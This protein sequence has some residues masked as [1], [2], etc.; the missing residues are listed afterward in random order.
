M[1][2]AA[3]GMSSPVDRRVITGSTAPESTGKAKSGEIHGSFPLGGTVQDISVQEGRASEP[4]PPAPPPTPSDSPTPQDN[5]SPGES[6]E[7]HEMVT[8]DRRKPS[9]WELRI[10]ES[11]EESA[12]DAEGEDEEDAREDLA[13][14]VTEGQVEAVSRG[15][16]LEIARQAGEAVQMLS[17][18]NPR[19][20]E[21][22]NPAQVKRT[23]KQDRAQ[24]QIHTQLNRTPLILVFED[25]I[26]I[27][28]AYRQLA[29]IIEEG[30]R[31]DRGAGDQA[32]FQDLGGKPI[33][34]PRTVRSHSNPKQGNSDP[35]IRLPQTQL[36]RLRAAV[37]WGCQTGQRSL[38]FVQ[39]REEEISNTCSMELHPTKQEH[40]TG[41]VNDTTLRASGTT[42][43]EQGRNRERWSTDN[44]EGVSQVEGPAVVEARSNEIRR[45]TYKKLDSLE[46][47]IREL[48]STLQEISA[49]PSAGHLFSQEFLGRLGTAPDSGNTQV[50]CPRD[51]EQIQISGLLASTDPQAGTTGLEAT[52]P[53]TRQKPPVPPKPTALPPA[54]A[55]VHSHFP[56]LPHSS[57]IHFMRFS[58]MVSATLSGMMFLILLF[59]PGFSSCHCFGT[60]E[61]ESS[62]VFWLRPDL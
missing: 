53:V 14:V 55:K 7:G 48:E 37:E 51:I 52:S 17:L 41:E 18:P 60:G 45:S 28:A 13:F 46:E 44:R 62:A 15:E 59:P 42:G 56:S 61:R 4:N 5:S 47:T 26:G 39:C 1:K 25:S 38:Q 36:R 57:F 33:P 20:E 58:S 54:T 2:A 12:L 43:S 8:K 3:P 40:G 35:K 24:H 6:A 11:F 49:H 34:K 31:G 9:P 23:M 29:A 21:I 10:Q 32:E 30:D 50:D 22:W 27:R 16:A 19:Q